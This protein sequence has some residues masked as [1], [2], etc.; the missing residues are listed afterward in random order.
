MGGETQV[1]LLCRRESCLLLALTALA[2]AA[3][4]AFIFPP[5]SGPSSSA[6]L[7]LCRC[8]DLGRPART[9]SEVRW[10]QS[11]R[12]QVRAHRVAAKA[13]RCHWIADSF[14]TGADTATALSRSF[15]SLA[16][17]FSLAFYC[18][19]PE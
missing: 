17:S 12:K 19:R 15:S 2:C 7:A 3:V 14:E 5:T 4:G 10:L 13:F 8:F 18:K 11:R 16:A 1:V 9:H 6:T